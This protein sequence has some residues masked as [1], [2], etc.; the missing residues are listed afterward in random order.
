V[1]L[2]AYQPLTATGV[3]IEQANK[4]AKHMA[5]Y[6]GRGMGKT[7]AMELERMRHQFNEMLSKPLT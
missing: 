7:A 1:D 6:N 4:R 3:M 2:E 5:V